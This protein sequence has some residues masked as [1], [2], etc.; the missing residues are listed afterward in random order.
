MT[1]A[2]DDGMQKK[3]KAFTKKI[4]V[5][6]DGFPTVLHGINDFLCEP[7]TNVMNGHTFEKMGMRMKASEIRFNIYG[8][9]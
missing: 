1:F 3:W 7:Y 5:K 6:T 4:G 8:V 2:S 9:V